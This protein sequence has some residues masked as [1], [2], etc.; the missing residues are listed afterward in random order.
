[1]KF[2]PEHARP[3]LSRRNDFGPFAPVAL[4]VSFVTR[5]D[6]AM[7]RAAGMLN[8]KSNLLPR[9]QAKPRSAR[10]RWVL[11]GVEVVRSVPL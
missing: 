10:L 8:D 2:V 11:D 9:L 4:G 3:L 5:S 1:M 7:I 6:G